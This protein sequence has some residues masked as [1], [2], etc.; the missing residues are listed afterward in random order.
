MR[1]SPPVSPQREQ[2]EDLS[3]PVSAR[4]VQKLSASPEKK[5]RGE[6]REDLTS[7]VVKGQAAS[8]LIELMRRG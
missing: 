6:V 2:N 4:T 1:S 8:S 5:E 3:T 7:S